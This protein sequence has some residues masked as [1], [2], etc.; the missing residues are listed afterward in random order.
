MEG[1]E[2][3]LHGKGI[4]RWSPSV[5]LTHKQNIPEPRGVR[6]HHLLTQVVQW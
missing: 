1:E 5:W 2:V 6:L 3:W 4:P